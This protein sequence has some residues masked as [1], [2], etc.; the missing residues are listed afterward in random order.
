[1][2]WFG[3]FLVTL[4]MI[5]LLGLLFWRLQSHH[6][7]QQEQALHRS[8]QAASDSISNR[9][10]V[11]ESFLRMLANQ[12]AAGSLIASEFDKLASR[13]VADHPDISA[14][15]YTRPDHTIQWS[16]PKTPDEDSEVLAQTT[17]HADAFKRSSQRGVSVYTV[18]HVGLAGHQGFD[19]YLPVNNRK[20][21]IGTFVLSYSS[22]ALILNS[23]DSA[24]LQGYQTELVNHDNE[25]VYHTPAVASIDPRLTDTIELSRPDNGLLLRLSKYNTPFW[26]SGTVLLAA[27]SIALISG[28]GLGLWALNRQIVERARIE[29]ALHEANMD[30]ENRVRE[31]TRALSESND[32][33]AREMTERQ[34]IE[35]R[36]RQHR[37]QLAQIGRVSTLGEMAAGLAHELHQPLGAITSY[38]KGCLRVLNEP[39]PDFERLRYAVTHMN[40][41]STRAADIIDRLRMFLTPEGPQKLPHD[42]RF[43]IDEAVS[44]VEPDSKRLGIDLIIDIAN[45]TPAVFVDRV[46]IEQVLVNLLK[47][48]F[49]SMESCEPGKRIVTV[50]AQRHGESEVMVRVS[51]TGTGCNL[52]EPTRVFE[53]FVTTK[54]GGMGM[55]LSISRTIIEAHEGR[56]WATTREPSG[57]TFSFTV[58]AHAHETATNA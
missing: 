18:P 2:P 41:Q 22:P 14:I 3:P 56:L 42:M 57:M 20:K 7:T 38:A 29:R 39:T 11:D 23:L 43:L 15:Y 30:L 4:T 31:R 52:D 49:E 32:R 16:S 27:I 9:L 21:H 34:E 35:E 17:E 47:N 10:A 37:D 50:Q 25:W 12:A 33:L 54:L 28:M 24:I 51:D 26:D 58:S 6:F 19:L 1:M 46:Q 53:P 55:G 36:A 44:F 40:E 8:L 45:D 48:A 5:A 13:Y